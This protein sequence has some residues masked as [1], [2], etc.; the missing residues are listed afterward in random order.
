MPAKMDAGMHMGAAIDEVADEELEEYDEEEQLSASAAAVESEESA[1]NSSEVSSITSS[2]SFFNPES[3]IASR[4]ESLRGG[5][6]SAVG[7]KTLS[8]PNLRNDQSSFK[9]S[10]PRA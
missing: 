1:T 2:S 9:P 3:M 4:S 8:A 10:F 5:R 7:S 6:S